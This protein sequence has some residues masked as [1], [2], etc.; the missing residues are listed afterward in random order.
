VSNF[1]SHKE[2]AFSFLYYPIE[3]FVKPANGFSSY[4]CIEYFARRGF[5]VD[6]SRS[7]VL[8]LRIYINLP[9]HLTEED[10]LAI[11][12]RTQGELYALDEETKIKARQL[13][14]DKNWNNSKECVI[15]KA[16]LEAQMAYLM[17]SKVRDRQYVCDAFDR[18]NIELARPK[19]PTMRMATKT[20]KNLVNEGKRLLFLLWEDGRLIKYTKEETKTK[21]E[22]YDVR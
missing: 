21:M 19:H 16:Y 6:W 14:L 4:R 3:G 22:G 15:T 10:T 13:I 8:Q 11:I 1:Y 5:E 20:T 7:H 18:Y 12:T 17:S 9:L 2:G